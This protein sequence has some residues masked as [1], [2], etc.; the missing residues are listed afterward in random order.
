M[1]DDNKFDENKLKLYSLLVDQIQKYN[2]IIWQVPT[3]LVAA[4]F[5]A[6]DKFF[7]NPFLLLMLSI[8]NG[9]LIYAYH[10]MVLQQRAI[11][12]ATRK[13][14]DDI[15]ETYPTF[16]PEFCRAGI[17]APSLLVYL[18]WVLDFSLLIYAVAQLCTKL[19]CT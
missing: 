4:N 18:L 1:P 7:S 19:R 13:A 11:I 14:E 12:D 9:V 8:F 10:R 2:A 6:L 5:F 16:I 15:K 3:A 17:R